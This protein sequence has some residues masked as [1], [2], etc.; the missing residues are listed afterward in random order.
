MPLTLADWIGALL[1]IV[2][3]LAAIGAAW[4]DGRRSGRP[5]AARAHW[6]A[7]AALFAGM[8][9][10]RLGSGEERL[11]AILRG[12][13]VEGGQYASRYTLQ[14]PLIAVLV[15]LALAIGAWVIWRWRHQPLYRAISGGGALGLLAFSLLRLMSYHPFDRLIYA[16]L[17]P[18]RLNYL[19]ELALIGAVFVGIWVMWTPG[20]E[21]SRTEGEKRRNARRRPR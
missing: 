17:G 15:V 7:I 4:L 6:L 16:S 9:A 18:L 3:M 8:A 14:G 1:Y 20:D 10:W 2:T 11:Q 19:I 12:E 5:A 21:Q 13:L